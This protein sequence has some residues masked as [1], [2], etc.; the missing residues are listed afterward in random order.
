MKRVVFAILICVFCTA[1][2]CSCDSVKY[3]ASCFAVE[4]EKFQESFIE[5][6]K[7]NGGRYKNP[8]YDPTDFESEEYFFEESDINQIVTTITTQ[9]EYDVVFV[10]KVCDIDFD[11]EMLVLTIFNSSEHDFK[12]KNISASSNN[13]YITLKQKVNTGDYFKGIF[14]FDTGIQPTP[15]YVI[16]KLQ[17][18]NY[19]SVSVEI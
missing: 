10:E 11:R 3:G 16:I 1:V 2:F 19:D 12:I 9:D 4:S 18:V 5:N 8:N 7:I 13:L 15:R 6:N 17:K 14:G